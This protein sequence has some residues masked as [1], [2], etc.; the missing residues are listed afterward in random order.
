MV[1]DVTADY[2]LYIDSYEWSVTSLGTTI[3]I[4]THTSGQ[5]R[6]CR[7]P[8]LYWL[9]RVVSD[10]T[11][12]YH[13]YIDSYEW[14]VTSLPTTISILTH[15]SGQWRHCRLPIS[16]LTHSSGQWRHCRLPS[17]YWLTSVAS[18]VTADSH[19]WPLPN[20]YKDKAGQ[21]PIIKFLEYPSDCICF[22]GWQ[23]TI[24]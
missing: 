5:W 3:S 21:V 9:I 10:V 18:D 23:Y 13:L 16:I 14:S 6:H 12:D 8:S 2:H 17:L 4:L 11:G 15:M 22:E 20:P 19:P 7:L 1:S 24:Y